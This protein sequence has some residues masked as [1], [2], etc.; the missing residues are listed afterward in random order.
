MTKYIAK[1]N[2]NMKPMHPGEMVKEIVENLNRPPAEIASA[3]GITLQH[4]EAIM[5]RTQPITPEIATKLGKLFGNG[6][7]L[8]L[9]LQARYDERT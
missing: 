2:P 8:W 1:Q 6:P 9:R 5:A 3:I 4:L 7:E